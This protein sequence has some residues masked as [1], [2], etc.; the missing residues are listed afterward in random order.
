MI[1]S[2]PKVE[3][4]SHPADGNL[5]LKCGF[6]TIQDSNHTIEYHV[7]WIKDSVV[8]DSEVHNETS[9]EIKI[10]LDRKHVVN[11]PYGTKVIINLST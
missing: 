3:V 2:N 11:L 9:D 4:E 8:I 10:Y 7:V 6:P 5:T 1:P